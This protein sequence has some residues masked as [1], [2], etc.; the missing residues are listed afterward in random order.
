MSFEDFRRSN[1]T[2][3]I[4]VMIAKKNRIPQTRVN[5][6]DPLQRVGGGVMKKYRYE[7]NG[8][9]FYWDTAKELGKLVAESGLYLA[10]PFD[11][12]TTDFDDYIESY[13]ESKN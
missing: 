5:Q 12:G 10:N 3:E 1:I 4:W 2:R 11:P 13:R 8:V 6:S 7:V 9:S